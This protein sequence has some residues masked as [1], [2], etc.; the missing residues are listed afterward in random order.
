MKTHINSSYPQWVGKTLTV[1]TAL[2]LLYSVGVIINH[3]I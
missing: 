3:F 1:I 2:G